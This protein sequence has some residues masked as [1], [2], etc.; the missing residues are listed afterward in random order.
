MGGPASPER[1]KDVNERYHDV[2]AAEYDAKWGID[3]GSASQNQVLGKMRKAL[4]GQPAEPFGDALEI[5]AGTGYFSL[6]LLQA[7]IIERATAT[8][9]SP[10]ML[11]ELDGNAERLGV[12]VRTVATDAESLSFADESFDLVFG[13]AILHHIPDLSRGFAEFQRVLRPGGT[14]VFCGEP[15]RYGD[16][17]AA[18]PKRAALVA[19]PVWRRLV[20]A[21][22]RAYE[23]EDGNGH[24][25]EAEVDVHAFSP[26]ALRGFAAGAGFDQIRVQGEELL[27]NVHGWTMRT[28]EASAVPEQIPSGWR[29]FAFRSYLA[30]QRIDSRLLEPRLPPQLFYNLL[31]SARRP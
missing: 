8:D 10:G 21:S 29:R 13:H 4:G 16:L 1:I 20:G 25:L 15:S 23:A 3:Y 31:I 24:A 9:I 14:L 5:G 19:A 30:L 28:L 27:A 11:R 26:G 12:E 2:A 7:G 17:L 22:R 6:N 18:A